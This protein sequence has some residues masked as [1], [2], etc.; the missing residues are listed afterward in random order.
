MPPIPAR[1]SD[2]PVRA[3]RALPWVA[4]ENGAFETINNKRAFDSE[5]FGLCQACGH[6]LDEGMAVAIKRAVT[7]DR[8]AGGLPLH[9]E[10]AKYA[11]AACPHL[12]HGEWVAVAVRGWTPTGIGPGID[13]RPGDV[14][15]KTPLDQIRSG[16]VTW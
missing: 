15:S 16:A 6:P 13:W 3:G 2:L 10:C 12:Q 7:Q 11:A 4:G 14:I 5:K 1:M 9:P 8:N